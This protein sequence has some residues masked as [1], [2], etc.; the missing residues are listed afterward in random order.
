MRVRPAVA[1]LALAALPLAAAADDMQP[2]QYKVTS[3]SDIPG[4][5]PSNDTHCITQKD[6][7]SGLSEMGIQKSSECK[8]ADFKKTAG[9]VSYRVVCGSDIGSQRVAGTFSRDAF[10]LKMEIQLEP[11]AR[12][13]NIRLAGKRIGACTGK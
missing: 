10:D 5:K 4:D 3:T 11:K 7:D 6:I 12:P 13:N 8:V 9:S 2:G 1:L